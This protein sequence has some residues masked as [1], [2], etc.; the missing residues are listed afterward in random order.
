[1]LRATLIGA[2]LLI[3][4]LAIAADTI[5]HKQIIGPTA[6]LSVSETGMQYDA[7]I[8]TGAVETSIHAYGLSIENESANKRENVGKTV[9]FTTENELGERKQMTG[10]ITKTSLIR[11][12]QGSEVRYKVEL[13]VGRKGEERKIG[14]NLRDRSHMNY[15]LLIGRDWLSGEYLVDVSLPEEQR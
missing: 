1:M 9:R 15:K 4:G 5:P 3:S 6:I 12:S 2:G 10:V 8:D 7:R 11:N 14:V 13:S